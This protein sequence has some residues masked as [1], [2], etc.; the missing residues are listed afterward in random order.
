MQMAEADLSRLKIDRNAAPAAQTLRRRVRPWMLV[1]AVR[2][3]ARRA[4]VVN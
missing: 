3:A 4:V 1:T 2:A